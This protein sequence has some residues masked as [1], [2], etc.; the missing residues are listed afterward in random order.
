VAEVSTMPQV[1]AARTEWE[2]MRA[3]ERYFLEQEG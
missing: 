1:Q 3:Q 2:A